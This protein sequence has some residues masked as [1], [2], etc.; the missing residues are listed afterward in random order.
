MDYNIVTGRT[1]NPIAKEKKNRRIILTVLVKIVQGIMEQTIEQEVLKNVDVQR[2]H[3]FNFQEHC[4]GLTTSEFN[5]MYRM[6]FDQF[7]YLR[8]VIATFW[9]RG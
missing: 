5:R 7:M 4:K 1:R 6:S 8:D 3:S 2:R 9:E